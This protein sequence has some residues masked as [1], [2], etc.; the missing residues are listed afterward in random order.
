MPVPVFIIAY[1]ATWFFKPDGR[2]LLPE[3]IE[4]ITYAIY[5]D[6]SNPPHQEH[7]RK[8]LA[9]QEVLL[10]G[11]SRFAKL[12]LIQQVACLLGA[13]L[14]KNAIAKQRFEGLKGL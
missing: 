4:R 12:G 5:G 7:L 2:Q 3:E 14:Q 9:R 10:E 1:I 11:L 8:R 6:Y 13:V